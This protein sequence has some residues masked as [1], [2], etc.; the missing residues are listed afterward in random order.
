MRGRF[1]VAFLGMMLV[2]ALSGGQQ[3]ASMPIY[4]Q[5]ATPVAESLRYGSSVQRTFDDGSG[6]FF[7]IF[8]AQAG[9]LITLTMVADRGQELDPALVLLDP[10]GKVIAQNDD[11]L[12]AAFGLLNARLVYFPIPATGTYTIQAMRSSSANGS[13]KL[14]L[15][16]N[17]NQNTT[18]LDYGQSGTGT[19]NDKAVHVSY[20]FHADPGD[21]ISITV[22]SVSGSDLIPY[23]VLLGTNGS[24]L[25]S[26]NPAE[27]ISK[28]ARIT[29]YPIQT[30]GTY[31][32]IVSRVGEEKGTSS[33]NFRLT[34][35]LA[36]VKPRV[37]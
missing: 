7:F 35:E 1:I 6:P 2:L 25:T 8:E 21:V 37:S 27:R 3:A 16:G 4:L 29:R 32:I 36:Q 19:I 18:A 34:L 28:T 10:E 14:T 5:T 24:K 33:G 23:A 26:T 9:D 12:D 15:R 22:Q 13:F 11:S 20:Q 17:G 30:E 31:T